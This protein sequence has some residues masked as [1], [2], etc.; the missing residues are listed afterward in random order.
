MRN[1]VPYLTSF[2]NFNDDSNVSGRWS[3]VAC[4][5][6]L[7]FGRWIGILGLGSLVLVISP[8]YTRQGTRDSKTRDPFV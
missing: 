7:V 6:S 4:L 2:Y 1:E 8:R 3:L 5:W